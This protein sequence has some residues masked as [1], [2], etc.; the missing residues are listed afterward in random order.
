MKIKCI[1]SCIALSI[2]LLS[3]NNGSKELSE[4][5]LAQIDSLRIVNDLIIDH[6]QSVPEFLDAITESLDIISK[7]D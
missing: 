5:L 6:Q 3:C 4:Q 7:N 1:F 2:V